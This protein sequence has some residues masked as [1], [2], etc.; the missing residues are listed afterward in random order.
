MVEHAPLPYGAKGIEV[1]DFVL[2]QG[3]DKLVILAKS[4]GEHYTL[5]A[6][7]RSGVI[8]LHRTWLDK[9]GVK[10]HETL[11]AIKHEELNKLLMNFDSVQSELR[12]LWRPLRV[13]WLARQG[14]GIVQGLDPVTDEQLAKI[15]RKR[16]K[17]LVPDEQ[18][19]QATI[20]VP[21]YLDDVYD[22]PDGA[23]SL[24]HGMKKVGIGLKI[25]DAYGK[26]RLYWLRLRDLRRL[27]KTLQERL[28]QSAAQHAI[29]TAEYYKY[30]DL[31]PPK[32]E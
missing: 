13:G 12:R 11:F 14:I 1:G 25:T 21:E 17:R 2:E 16:K 6:G 4:A 23:F 29:P 18:L 15:T 10:H 7:T 5:Q 28:S 26:T 27:A 32:Q 30:P 8:D 31:S 3:R 19:L 9:D 22:F 20:H 24:F